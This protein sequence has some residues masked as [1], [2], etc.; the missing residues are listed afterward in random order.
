MKS[1]NPENKNADISKKL[2]IPNYLLILLKT[3]LKLDGGKNYV[4]IISDITKLIGLLAK[5]TFSKNLG[6]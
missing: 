1:K 5:I 3:M 4:E 6:I 2:N